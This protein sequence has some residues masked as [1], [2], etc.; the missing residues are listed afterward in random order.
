MSHR[1]VVLALALACL[2]AAPAAASAA[3]GPFTPG[4]PGLGDPYFPLD[5]NGGYDT[6]H[7]QLDLRYD[8]ATDVLQ[9]VATIE[10]EATQNLST[11]NLDLNG[12]NVRLIT[13]DGR[14]ARWTRDG[15]ELTITPRGGI[16][17][18]RDFRT[19]IVYDGVPT[20]VGDA[21]IGLS[22]FIA[23]DDG[24][25]VAGQPEVADH[26]YPVNDHPLDKA[27]YE[28]RVNVP[29][30]TEAVANGELKSH[31]TSRGRTTWVWEAKEPMASYLTTVDI[32][33]FDLKAY[34]DD[35]IEYVDALD[36]DLFASP[37]PA[38]GS[39]FAI[40][41]AANY[42]YKRLARTIA[43]P[44]GGGQLSFQ[45]DRDTERNWDF[46]FVEARHA[47]QDDWTTLPDLHGHTSAGLS[48][49]RCGFLFE[50]H[51]FLAHYLTDPGGN[52]RCTAGGTTGAWNAATGASN[53][54]ET[55]AVDL[56]AYA[57]TNVELSISYASDD[58]IQ[59]R[60]LVVDDIVGPGGA[61]STS[62]ESDGDPLDGWTVP[63][64]P[65]GTPPNAND[66]KVGGAADVPSI[67]SVARGALDRQP[68][69]IDFLA[70]IWGRY[71]FSAAGGIVDDLQGLGFALETQTRP[72]YSLEFFNEFGDPA[73]SVVVHELAHQWVGDDVALAAWPHIWL[74]EGFATY[75]EWLWAE[76]QQRATAQD[77]FDF[78]ASLPADDPFWR[79]KIGD[80]G[81][82]DLFAGAVYDRGAMTLHA[83]RLK[84]GD[85][86]FFR[87]L[88]R[89]VNQQEGANA[90]I[91]EFIALAEKLSKQNLRAF[92]D[93][94]LFTAAKPASLAAVAAAGTPSAAA[95]A[96]LGVA[97][98]D[99]RKPRPRP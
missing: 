8:P 49:N 50:L 75:S 59:H 45:V 73:D 27:S 80:P 47:G 79:L 83:L 44:A 78:Y 4:A 10:A 37:S 85:R 3:S 67:G 2:A 74:N 62:F 55:W 96:K 97:A 76:D 52:V 12:L 43:V 70:G 53:G 77:Y 48:N 69:I 60:G 11:F 7:Y 38:T 5:G 58:T 1:L 99:A 98:A 51:P 40:S 91:S 33:Q 95:A 29:A 31:R 35:G 6:D 89:W 14:P 41:Q 42:S 25:L 17:N 24:A 72:V 30:G 93:E 66:W 88:K 68:E 18:G 28:F 26:W 86:E 16:R 64:A 19:V 81:P 94:W 34:R 63:G 20:P 87:L 15:D 57:G 32:G 9:G 54:Y 82:D 46:M 13:V 92:F 21:Q 71:P 56:G 39:R 36:P 84:L 23:T 90:T 61:G 65:A 22:G